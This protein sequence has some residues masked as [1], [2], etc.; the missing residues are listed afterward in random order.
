MKVIGTPEFNDLEGLPKT[1]GNIMCVCLFVVS[2]L[3]NE[4]GMT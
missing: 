1:F 3:F 2:T 4:I